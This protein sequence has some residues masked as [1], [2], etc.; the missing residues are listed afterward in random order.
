MRLELDDERLRARVSR[1]T[2]DRV[3]LVL[4]YPA[5]PHYR[6]A[7]LTVLSDLLRPAL[8]LRRVRSVR[9]LRKGAR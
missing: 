3:R 6:D 8:P 5:E 2:G 4:D 1:L 9:L 7:V